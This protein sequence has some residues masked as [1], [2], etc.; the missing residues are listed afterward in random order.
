MRKFVHFRAFL[1]ISLV[2]GRS[3]S[4]FCVLVVENVMCVTC[5]VSRK[6][7]TEMNLKGH[8]LLRASAAA[9]AVGI[10]AR[11][12]SRVVRQLARVPACRPLS[13]ERT[14]CLTLGRETA[15]TLKIDLR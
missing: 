9:L 2:T 3:R 8:Q 6:L 12:V 10:T 1:F 15:V 4:R 11:L 7:R 5:I 13:A 14:D